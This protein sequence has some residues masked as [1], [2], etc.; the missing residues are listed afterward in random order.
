MIHCERFYAQNSLRNFSYL[1]FDEKTGDAWVIDPFD[2]EPFVDYIKKHSLSLKGILNTHQHFD[3]IRGNDELIRVFKARVLHP[4]AGEPIDLDPRNR[5][6]ITDTPG[7]TRDHQ[8]FVWKGAE[9]P[10]VLFSG[11]TL[12]NAGVGNCKNG[13]NVEDLY[14]STQRLLSEL[15][16]DTV[17][18]PGHDYLKR[19]LEFAQSV[20]PENVFVRERLREIADDP[21]MRRPLTMREEVE[22]NPF[23]KASRD[24]FI[25]LRKLRDNW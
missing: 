11:D 14:E 5:L 3:H 9:N 19:N 21:L 18:Q 22:I 13:G 16:L 20:D 2:A 12:F 6:E 24:K 25:E 7:H 15:P 8:V 10:P 1:V 4:H 23:L 17:L